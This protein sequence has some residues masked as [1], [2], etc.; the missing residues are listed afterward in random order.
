M[1]ISGSFDTYSLPEL[2]RLIDS[3]SKSGRLI[4][5]TLSVLKASE[6]KEFELFHLWFEKGRV[7]AIIDR[8]N[9]QKNLLALIQ[10]RGWIS[11]V[12]IQQLKKLC[13]TLVPL[14][15]YLQKIK[16]MRAKQLNLLFQ[17]QLHQ[18]YQLFEVPSGWFRFDDLS[19]L[20]KT[21]ESKTFPCHEMTGNSIRATEVTIYALRLVKDQNIFAEQ[22]PDP[23]DALRR[24]VNQPTVR[25]TSL[26]K[27][28]W[29]FTN[30]K[31]SI[32]SIARQSNKSIENVQMTAFR[33]VMAGLLEETFLD[34]W[35]SN[36]VAPPSLPPSTTIEPTVTTT[37]SK[38]VTEKPAVSKSLL[39]NLLGFLR[40]VLKW[41]S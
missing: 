30:G 20:N 29:E 17:I 25:L 38:Q 22:L 28:I 35:N 9:H 7:V 2:F 37:S 40:G 32:K 12:N 16:L 23:N 3:G 33:L 15:V 19:E 13:L 10:S 1:T 8:I 11:Q 39:N 18:V 24:L 34:A 6:T 26:E 27:Q 31:T 41:K 14:G 4:I 36:P 5:Q 21:E